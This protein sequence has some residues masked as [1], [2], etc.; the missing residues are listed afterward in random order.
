MLLQLGQ[1]LADVKLEP[2]C[3]DAYAA[4]AKPMTTIGFMIFLAFM[5]LLMLLQLGQP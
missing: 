2:L 1:L 4:A 3:V 5:R